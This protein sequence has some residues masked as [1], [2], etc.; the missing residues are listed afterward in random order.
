MAVVGKI[1]FR[2]LDERLEL[3]KVVVSPAS[4]TTVEVWGRVFAYLPLTYWT[5]ESLGFVI[6]TPSDLKTGDWTEWYFVYAG[7]NYYFHQFNVIHDDEL[8]GQLVF[9]E[10]RSP[11]FTSVQIA[12]TDLPTHNSDADAATGGVAL[13]DFYVAGSA[14]DRAPYGTI[15]R[16]LE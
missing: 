4:D 13:N 14:H 7:L 9:I 15:T 12:L 2:D 3:H 10:G 6:Q 16:R 5:A 1:H 8:N 11:H